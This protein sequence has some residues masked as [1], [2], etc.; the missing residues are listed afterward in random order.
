MAEVTKALRVN[1]DRADM[2]RH[3]MV[4]VLSPDA[5]PDIRVGIANR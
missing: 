2:A 3:N 4:E 1:S 5:H